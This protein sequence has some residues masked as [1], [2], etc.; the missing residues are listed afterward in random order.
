LIKQPGLIK[1]EIDAVIATRHFFS[2][3]IE[4]FTERRQRTDPLEELRQEVYARLLKEEKDRRGPL[5]LHLW[6]LLAAQHTA[7]VIK[8]WRKKRPLRRT[9]APWRSLNVA[10]G[11]KRTVRHEDLA[12]GTARGAAA[13]LLA[14]PSSEEM[15]VEREELALFFSYVS[16]LRD[17]IERT[18]VLLLYSEALQGII[19]SV[20]AVATE[21][22]GIADRKERT[23]R[24]AMSENNQIEARGYQLQA[25]NARGRAVA[26]RQFV[27][28][29]QRALRAAEPPPGLPPLP[30]PGPGARG[31]AAR[32]VAT[33]LGVDV[34]RLA[35]YEA[36][37]RAGVMELAAV[38]AP[39][40]RR[41]R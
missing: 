33:W 14:P 8:D 40:R 36:N 12:A 27:D 35:Q 22:D 31:Y 7:A 17:E 34:P 11:D 5:P 1:D 21:F 37:L 30:E 2:A 4:S 28:P 38:R 3:E 20:L 24:Q 9:R 23:A 16:S 18:A 26:L 41:H 13:G 32:D 6:K 15:V 10:E 29:V 25:T 39:R 19:Q